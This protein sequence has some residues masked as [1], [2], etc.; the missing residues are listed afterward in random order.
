MRG[1]FAVIPKALWH[2]YAGGQRILKSEF[3]MWPPASRS[4]RG[5]RPGGKAEIQ[6]RRD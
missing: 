3:G 1:I 6:G 4:H 5:L 2:S